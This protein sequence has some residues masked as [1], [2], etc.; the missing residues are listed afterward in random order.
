MV[1]KGMSIRGTADV[2]KSKILAYHSNNNTI[3]DNRAMTNGNY[4]IS[5]FE[6][7]YNNSISGNIVVRN[8]EKGISIDGSENAIN[9]N[10]L[11]EN[12]KGITITSFSRNNTVT[13]NNVSRSEAGIMLMLSRGNKLFGN[14]VRNNA[15]GI[16]LEDTYNNTF[17]CNVMQDNEIGISIN[18]SSNNLIYLNKFIDNVE[19]ASS[20]NSANLWNS[21]EP[22]HYAYKDK[23]FMNYLGNYWSDYDR[24]EI[25][26]DGIGN[27][28]RRIDAKNAD[29]YPLIPYLRCDDC[30]MAMLHTT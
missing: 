21:T 3:K 2:L 11:S 18:G 8:R 5:I 17:I 25:N 10:N 6:N 16:Y 27:M 22:L 15:K 24:S 19:S 26:S 29:C 23:N 7:S 4:G 9:G 30:P 12:K 20:N 1:T 13:G 14:S 28:P